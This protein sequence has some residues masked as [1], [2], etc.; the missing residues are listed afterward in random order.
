M[1][2][3]SV[4]IQ[5]LHVDYTQHCRGVIYWEAF[6]I[7]AIQ[8][9]TCV[10]G[11]D[12]ILLRIGVFSNFKTTILMPVKMIDIINSTGERSP[13][14][15]FGTKIPSH[16]DR[17]KPIAPKRIPSPSNAPNILPVGMSKRTA[18][19]NSAFGLV[20]FPFMHLSDNGSISYVLGEIAQ[21]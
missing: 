14:G 20:T 10:G 11:R 17:W 8:A 3:F 12:G 9:P 2:H 6:E 15:S 19:I 5:L 1:L 16:G 13:P 18:A 7:W 4:F 21:R